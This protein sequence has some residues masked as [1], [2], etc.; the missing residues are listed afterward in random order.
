MRLA[1]LFDQCCLFVCLL[2]K[3]SGMG[4]ERKPTMTEYG[5]MTTNYIE[6]TDL[7]VFFPILTWKQYCC[8]C[9]CWL[10]GKKKWEDEM[11]EIR[12][13]SC[14]VVYAIGMKTTKPN[15]N[16]PASSPPSTQLKGCMLLHNTMNIDGVR[17]PLPLAAI[18]SVSH[19][20]DLVAGGGSWGAAA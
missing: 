7:N 9:M 4:V 17:R 2:A 14:Q 13:R 5:V 8:V 12:Y 10:G 18:E 19:V 1:C 16:Q 15:Q 20:W 3:R 11:C 6:L